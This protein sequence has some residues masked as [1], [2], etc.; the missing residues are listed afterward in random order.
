MIWNEFHYFSNALM[1]QTSTYVLLPDPAAMLEHHNRPVPT[2]YLLHGLS[3]DHTCWMRNTRIEQYARK[4]YVAVVMPAVQRS[5]YTDMAYGMKYF[6]FTAKELPAVL[7]RYFPLSKKREERFAA[8]LSMGGYGALKLG[9]RCP[10][11]YAAVASLSAPTMMHKSFEE[12][13]GHP[14]D[15]RELIAL[16]GD[17][18]RL[19][20]GN[21]NLC[22]L[23][24]K[25]DPAKAPKIYMACGAEDGLL[26]VNDEFVKLYGEK[27]GVEYHTAVGGHMWDFWD[28]QI[29]KVL[30]WL[31]LAKV[32]NVW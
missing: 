4:H 12:S 29:R 30:D 7:E 31:P 1:M 14:F 27:L 15:P 5:F 11:R 24:E 8:G 32:E 25:I 13:E 10:N 3:D 9:L 20:A 23:A 17:S 16:F 19:H 28:D 2:L 22:R 21:D 26:P 6:E 18:K